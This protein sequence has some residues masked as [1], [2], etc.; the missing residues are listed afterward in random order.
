MCILGKST[1]FLLAVVLLIGSSAASAAEP[2]TS[3]ERLAIVRMD[4]GGNVPPP[5]RRALGDRLMVGLQAVAFEVLRPGPEVVAGGGRDCS[6]AD[7]WRQMA[8]SLGVSYLVRAAVEENDKTFAITIELISGR[9]GIVVG[10]NRERCEICGAEEVSEKMNLAAATLRSRLE[11]IAQAPSRFVIRTRP[12]GASVKLD[13]RVVGRSPV[14]VSL[15]AGPHQVVIEREGFSP[16]ERELV[17]TSGVDETLDL[18]LIRLPTDFPYRVLG[19]SAIGAGVALAVSGIYVLSMDG[20][21]VTCS[22]NQKDPMGHCPR[23]Y[24]TNLLGASLLGLS[25]VSATL[26]G[27]WLYLAQPQETSPSDERTSGRVVGPTV[28]VG[29]SGTF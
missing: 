26:G 13:G 11:A 17:V 7:C 22:V 23:V 25:A 1:P 14:D 20:D 5:L 27:V 16:L 24:K 3:K 4:F 12:D 8:E 6:T 9:T 21:E 2:G 15:T 29:A 18:D 10:T 19:W 28:L